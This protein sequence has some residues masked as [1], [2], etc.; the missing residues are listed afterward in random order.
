MSSLT[1]LNTVQQKGYLS[2]IALPKKLGS[3]EVLIGTG[4][5]FKGVKGLTL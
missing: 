4:H 3:I 5:G 2:S 1:M